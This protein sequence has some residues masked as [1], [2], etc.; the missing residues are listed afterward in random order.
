MILSVNVYVPFFSHFY[1]YLFLKKHAVHV[2]PKFNGNVTAFTV[3]NEKGEKGK[4]LYPDENENSSFVV[5][6]HDLVGVGDLELHLVV[7]GETY[8]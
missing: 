7:S 4:I 8:Y 6:G 3:I 1:F 5:D 2:Y